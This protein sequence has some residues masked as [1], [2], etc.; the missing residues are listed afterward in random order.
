MPDDLTVADRLHS[1]TIHATDKGK[2]LL[3]KGRSSRGTLLAECLQGLRHEELVVLD[4]AS[5]ILER[6][7][8]VPKREA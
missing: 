3:Q 1:V 6:L 5:S 8:A 2:R 7:L 4:E